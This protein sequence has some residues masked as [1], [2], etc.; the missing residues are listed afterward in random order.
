MID[1][2]QQKMKLSEKQVK[3][4]TTFLCEYGFIMMDKTKGRIKISKN[5]QQ[6]LSQVATS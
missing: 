6:F 1:E 4:A 5:V 3:H 2:V